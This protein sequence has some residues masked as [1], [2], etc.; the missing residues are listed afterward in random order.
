MQFP[1]QI[2]TLF[3]FCNLQ[4]WH[5]YNARVFAES[6]HISTCQY[7]HRSQLYKYTHTRIHTHRD[8]P[9]H[10]GTVRKR[11][12]AVPCTQLRES[13]NRLEKYITFICI[14]LL[15]LRIAIHMPACTYGIYVHLRASVYKYFFLYI[16]RA[17]YARRTCI[18]NIGRNVIPLYRNRPSYTHSH[19]LTYSY[20]LTHAQFFFCLSSF[21][22]SFWSF[23][24]FDYFS[25]RQ[26][27]TF[28]NKY[29]WINFSVLF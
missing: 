16:E 28:S 8:T 5:I 25:A 20:S 19:T 23:F 17:I 4:E 15:Y 1:V 24:F 21:I 2:N 27:F 26:L 29:H 7:T 12:H 3:F 13:T 10:S 14:R 18:C 11:Q 6:Q 9:K 22:F